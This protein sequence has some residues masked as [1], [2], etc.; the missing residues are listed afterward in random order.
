MTYDS[1][2]HGILTSVDSDKT[3]QPP[4]MLRNSKLC[5]KEYSL[6][7]KGSDQTV[8]IPKLVMAFAGRTYH[9]VRNMSLLIYRSSDS[10]Y[11][12]W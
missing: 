8:P 4:F 10:V 3:V 11:T 1:Q 6:A 7:G 9:I 12:D 2:Q 5:F